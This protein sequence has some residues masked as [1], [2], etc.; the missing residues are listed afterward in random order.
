[1]DIT[2]ECRANIEAT[3]KSGASFDLKNESGERIDTIIEAGYIDKINVIGELLREI[4][5]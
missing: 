1:M 3:N 4:L 5:K 2:N